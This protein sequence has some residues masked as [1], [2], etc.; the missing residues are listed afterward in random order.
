MIGDK[1]KFFFKEYNGGLV[2]FGDDKA[3]LIK[4]KGTISF[5][6]KNNN[7]NVYYVEDLKH[8]LLSVRQLVEKGF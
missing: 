6:G 1:S 3:F 2:R 7:E 4:G 5:D 8:Y